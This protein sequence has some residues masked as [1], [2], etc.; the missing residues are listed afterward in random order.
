MYVVVILAVSLLPSRDVRIVVAELYII[1]ALSEMRMWKLS[2]MYGAISWCCIFLIYAGSILRRICTPG[3]VRNKP[4]VLIM[5]YA[6]DSPE[7]KSASTCMQFQVVF[8]KN[9][10]SYRQ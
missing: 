8:L 6:A 3:Q 10:P 5:S 9:G 7:Y 1:Q 4:L 2:H